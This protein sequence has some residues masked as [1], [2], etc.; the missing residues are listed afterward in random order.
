MTG[1]SDRPNVLRKDHGERAT[2]S[3]GATDVWERPIVSRKDDEEDATN[4]T[5]GPSRIKTLM[6]KPKVWEGKENE[7][8]VPGTIFIANSTVGESVGAVNG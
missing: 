3:M 8:I 5:V 6:V 2:P 7:N 4:Y 1:G